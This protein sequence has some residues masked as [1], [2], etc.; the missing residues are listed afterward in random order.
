MYVNP[1]VAGVIATIMVELVLII[2]IAL[3]TGNKK[4]D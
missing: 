1:F 3:F 2:G 4:K